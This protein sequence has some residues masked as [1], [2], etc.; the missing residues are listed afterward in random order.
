MPL[1]EESIFCFKRGSVF[2]EGL[3]ISLF[4]FIFEYN[5]S[6]V[7]HFI[8]RFQRY[9]ENEFAYKIFENMCE[10]EEV[11]FNRKT[12]DNHGDLAKFIDMNFE[13][14]KEN[15]WNI[16]QFFLNI[17]KYKEDFL[18]IF[19]WHYENNFKKIEK[20]VDEH[21][22]VLEKD[23]ETV[24]KKY[25]NDFVQRFLTG[26]F[27][28]EST[29]TFLLSISYF[30]RK[31]VITWEERKNNKRWIVAGHDYLNVITKNLDPQVEA[32]RILKVIADESRL[33]IIKL[34]SEKEY[35]NPEIADLLGLTKATISHH[36]NA[37]CIHNIVDIK[38][39]GN[40][41]F[42]SVNSEKLKKRLNNIIEKI[43]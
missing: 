20:Y 9:S 37:L 39:D 33:K 27:P 8:K 28:K 14:S 17:K 22:S 13:F 29:E 4:S 40:K 7:L 15:K 16:L 26:L 35:R 18:K 1:I 10:I 5:P 3:E 19:V 30:M 11:D 23:F 31:E 43:L 25:E 42:Y 12:F 36:M 21:V 24:V 38:R 2:S 34:L 41:I 6:S 32:L